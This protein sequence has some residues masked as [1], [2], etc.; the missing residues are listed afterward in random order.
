MCSSA[1]CD[2]IL[3]ARNICVA[4]GLLQ[5]VRHLYGLAVGVQRHVH[6][7]VRNPVLR[8]RAGHS[9]LQPC[10][11]RVQHHCF[12]IRRLH[13]LRRF[14]NVERYMP[15]AQA[16]QRAN[17]VIK[18]YRVSISFMTENRVREEESCP[19]M[20]AAIHAKHTASTQAL[21]CS[22]STPPF[23]SRIITSVEEMTIRLKRQP[24][25]CKGSHNPERPESSFCA[26]VPPVADATMFPAENTRWY[27]QHCMSSGRNDAAMT[28]ITANPTVP[29]SIFNPAKAHCPLRRRLPVPQRARR[30]SAEISR[31]SARVY[32]RSAQI[33]PCRPMSAPNTVAQNVSSHF[34]RRHT[35]AVNCERSR[36]AYGRSSIP[37]P[38][39][40]A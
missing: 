37:A 16:L 33:S 28:A 30:C 8:K 7:G 17:A 29:L 13:C 15:I 19:R 26:L 5:Y 9:I 35:E 40:H 4:R 34:V 21:I 20:P 3:H 38:A 10:A 12:R 36:T 39:A 31:F 2:N 25:K 27:A 1:F 14:R 24:S 11:H 18:I 6:F 22:N 23:P 32:P